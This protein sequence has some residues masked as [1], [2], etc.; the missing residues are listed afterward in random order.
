[1]P[2]GK[3]PLVLCIM[4]GWGLRAEADHN[5]VVLAETPHTD[6][7]WDSWPHARLAASGEEV[8]LP[9]G[10][11]GNSEVG[12]LTIGAGRLIEQDLPRINHAVAEGSLAS[13]PAFAPF[14][15]K[16]KNAS[17]RVHL[18]GLVSE[19]GVHAH[20]LHILALAS[21]CLEAGLRVVLHIITDGRDTLPRAADDQLGRFIAALDS[22]VEI[23][24]LIGRYFAM[25]RDQRWQRTQ[26]ALD[27]IASGTADRQ[28]ANP[29]EALALARAAEETD[30]FIQPTI[31]GGY[32]G[33]AE[34]DGVIMANFRVDRARQIM[35]AL[36]DRAATGCDV[37]AV[38]RLGGGLAMTPLSDQLDRQIPHLFGPP[39]LSGGL[40]AALAAAGLSQLRLAETE[41]YPHV[42]W[43]FNGGVEASFAGE[44]RKMVPSPQVAT[45]DMRP[46][47]SAAGVLEKALES[48]QAA[49]HDVIIVNFANPDMV[50]HT[51]DLA[52][53][54]KAV[55]AVDRCVG[56][57]SEAVL[58]TGG[59][60]I[61]TA[62]HGNCEIL[63]DHEAGS[64]HT[65]HT[66]SP[67]PVILA[68]AGEGVYLRDGTLA[69]LAPTMLFLLGLKPSKSMTGKNLIYT[70]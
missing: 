47:M 23:G 50:G 37:S 51:G 1:M 25:D 58:E 46:Q 54:I 17:G 26:R 30:E 19:G 57:L 60:I 5:A 7:L 70:G 42:T 66:T 11:P 45:Y 32:V 44:D 68:G 64:P 31:I 69:D 55:E 52:A 28:A 13:L 36:F 53:A 38:P 29:A 16:I 61:V 3:K 67:V 6:R 39:D 24:T 14:C 22:R 27:A 9:A 8:G 63:W 33:M 18:L 48:V 15:E 21:A 41:K 2:V 62:D 35:S 10:Q 49:D 56:R 40:G 12:H 4:D 59:Q 34:G 43:F 20:S 65:A